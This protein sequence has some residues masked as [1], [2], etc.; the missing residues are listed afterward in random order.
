MPRIVL[1][2]ISFIVAGK[3]HGFAENVA[4]GYGNCM[5][6]HVS[7]AGGGVLND[8]GRAL[9]KELMSTWGW[10]DSEKP[11]FGAGENTEWLKIGG[12]YRAIQTYFNNSEVKQGK[13]FEM[14]KNIE[15]ALKGAH[16]WIVGALGTQEGPE[17]IPKKGQFL[18]ERHYVLWEINDTVKLRAGKFRLNF[19]LYEPNHNR[20]TEQAIGFGPSSESYI[21]EFSKLSEVDEIFISAD[22]GR[23]DIPRD[24][25]SEKSFSLNY[26]KYTSEKSKIG[27]NLIIG[28]SESLRRSLFGLYGIGGFGERWILKSEIDYQ[29]SFAANTPNER[30]DLMTSMA[31]L[32]Y[33][34]TQGFLPYLILEHLQRNLADSDTKRSSAGIGVQWLP[35]PHIELQAEF[36]KQTQNDVAIKESDSGW[37]L[38]HFY[39]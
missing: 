12:D 18:S 28:E 14:Q 39:L 32:G 7:P 26:A 5:A 15:L 2:F 34:W 10:K 9:S 11:L 3:S 23:I 22:L 17:G 30:A 19:G 24:R 35:I 25:S 6:C 27:G 1:L 8:Y 36:K 20:L 21:L 38:F 13:Q 31:S 16:L 37:F 33:Q 29:Q 4:H